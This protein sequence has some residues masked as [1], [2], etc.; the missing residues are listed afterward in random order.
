MY[1]SD[2]PYASEPDQFKELTLLL[3]EAENILNNPVNKDEMTIK[4]NDMKHVLK[5]R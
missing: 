3:N 5:N 2:A 1:G 4:L